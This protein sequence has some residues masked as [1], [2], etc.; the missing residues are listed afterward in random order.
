MMG[1]WVSA[2]LGEAIG[3]GGDN[4]QISLLSIAIVARNILLDV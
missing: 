3:M 1:D 2:Y 4:G